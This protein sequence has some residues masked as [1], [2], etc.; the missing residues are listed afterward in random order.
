M[1]LAGFNH[2]FSES[3]PIEVAQRLTVAV[4]PLSVLVLLKI[5]AY[6]E[7]PYERERDLADFSLVLWYYERDNERRIYS[8]EILDLGMEHDTVPAWL[9]GTDLAAL[10]HPDEHAIV[11]RF[12]DRVGA[13][14]GIGLSQLIR[15]ARLSAPE[16]RETILKRIVAFQ[17]GFEK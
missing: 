7:S 10:C 9:L 1:S 11:R 12:L 16:D 15:A 5:S 2:V 17:A 13:E 4:V 6:L 8:P 14:T 3:G